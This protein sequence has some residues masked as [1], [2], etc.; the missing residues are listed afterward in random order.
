M[1]DVLAGA[2]RSESYSRI[3]LISDCDNC[4]HVYDMLAM[5]RLCRGTTS[6]MWWY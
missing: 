5:V 6:N 1:P 2:R 4:V 3:T